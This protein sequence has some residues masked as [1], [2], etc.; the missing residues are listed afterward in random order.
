MVQAAAQVMATA[1]QQQRTHAGAW[2]EEVRAAEE[3]GGAPAN[4][5]TTMLREM[6]GTSPGPGLGSRRRPSRS[7]WTLL[8]ESSPQRSHLMKTHIPSPP[9]SILVPWD[10]V[11]PAEWGA[12]EQCRYQVTWMSSV[13]LGTLPALPPWSWT[14]SFFQG[15]CQMAPSL[16]NSLTHKGNLPVYIP[17][18]SWVMDEGPAEHLTEKW[19]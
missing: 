13:P 4:E 16:T 1:H 19:G 12:W 11:A 9:S 10:P 2:T 3:E 5:G 18:L 8:V 6:R 7:F 17:K 14:D 15:R